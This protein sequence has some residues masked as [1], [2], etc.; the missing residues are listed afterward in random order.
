MREKIYNA[1]AYLILG[2]MLIVL[3]S[4]IGDPATQAFSLLNLF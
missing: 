3:S 4:A 2:A 1:I